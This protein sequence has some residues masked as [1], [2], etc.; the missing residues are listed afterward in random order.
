MFLILLSSLFV[1]AF[2]F[3]IA[4]INWLWTF[5]MAIVIVLIILNIVLGK[6]LIKQ[7]IRLNVA[8]KELKTLL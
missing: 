3:K 7:L 5:N 8:K 2:T 6:Q 4:Q 1:F